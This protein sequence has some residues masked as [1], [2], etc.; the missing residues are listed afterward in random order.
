MKNNLLFSMLAALLILAPAALAQTT[1]RCET[2]ECAF[3]GNAIV[4]LSHQLSN[5]NC[6]EGKTWG[7]R[8]N[9]IWV[10]NGCR[11]DFMI[12]QRETS[13]L[14]ASGT[15][16]RCES[17]GHRKTCVADTHY[18]V[19]LTRQLSKSGCIEGKSWGF[20]NNGVWVDN[21][22]RADF[23]L[24]GPTYSSGR[25]ASQTL[26]C[27][28]MNNTRHHCAIDTRMGVQLTRQ[29]SDNNCVFNKSWGYDN[30]GIWVDKGC[31]AEFSVGR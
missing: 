15:L 21:G 24:S 29:M 16:L 20:D 23:V 18:G 31:R 26:V 28:S 1:V 9:H 5:S 17:D 22:C 27:E 30:K 14:P 2:G 4:S 3:T 7:V 10:K 12:T 13:G 8:N 11:A 25:V 6:V 19:Q